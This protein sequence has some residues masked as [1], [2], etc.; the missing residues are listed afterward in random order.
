MLLPLLLALATPTAVAGNGPFMWGVGPTVS[1]IAYP[2]KHPLLFPKIPDDADG[3]FNRDVNDNGRITSL[4]EV[5]GDASVG[6]RGVIYL[7][8]DIRAGLRVHAY[9]FGA[10]YGAADFTIEAEKIFF[11]ESK[12]AAFAGAGIG[13]GKMT[14]EGD[15]DEGVDGLKNPKLEMS[16]YLARGQ[17]GGIY[18]MDKYAIELGLFAN[19]LMPGVV[20]FTGQSGDQV[21][22]DGVGG[23]GTYWHGGLE[24]T[25]YF[26]DFVPPKGHKSGNK[27]GKKKK[28]KKKKKGGRR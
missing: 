7:N 13:F 6:A 12:A 2:G 10:D 28:N 16:T 20:E 27:G 8:P 26:G 15:S 3:K 14:F 1:T 23:K 18:R 22:I 19:L 11:K 9:S 21:E 24:A 17:V 5:R 4:N 25:F